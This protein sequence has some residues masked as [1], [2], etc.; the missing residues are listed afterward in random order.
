MRDSEKAGRLHL[1]W[2]YLCNFKNFTDLEEAKQEN[3]KLMSTIDR[4]K[5]T[6]LSL[7]SQVDKVIS[8]FPFNTVIF[9]KNFYGSLLF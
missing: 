3:R 6:E 5:E 1:N 8:I 7:R 4:L 9:F 2:F